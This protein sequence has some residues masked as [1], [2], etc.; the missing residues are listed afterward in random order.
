MQSLTADFGLGAATWRTGQNIRV[1]FDSCLFTTLYVN[2]TSAT[3]NRKYIT[4][5]IVVK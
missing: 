3:K 1:V 2:V 5:L 4:Y